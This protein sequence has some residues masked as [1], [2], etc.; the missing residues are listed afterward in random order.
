MALVLSDIESDTF[1]C[2][3]GRAE[4]SLLNTVNFEQSL[5]EQ[6]IDFCRLKVNSAD[7]NNYSALA[8]LNMPYQFCGSILKYKMD[9]FNLPKPSYK[10]KNLTFE[11]Y[12]PSTQQNILANLV[13]ET[14]INDPIGYYKNHL[15][16]KILTKQQEVKCMAQWYAKHCDENIN[17]MV[18]MKAGDQYIGY[19]SIFKKEPNLVDTPIAGVLPKFQGQKM[20]DDLRTYRHLY[21]LENNIQYG[22]AGARIE[23]NYSQQTFINDGMQQIANQSIYIVTPFLSKADSAKHTKANKLQADKTIFEQ[24][25]QQQGIHF[26]MEGDKQAYQKRSLYIKLSAIASYTLSVP[27]NLND[28]K[29]VL[30]KYFDKAGAL[31]L[32]NWFEH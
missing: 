13:N 2:K 31:C 10:N 26:F 30:V 27:V 32:I 15:L 21:C 22:T 23:N 24:L 18:L 16:S 20:F 17:I 12:K 7:L 5:I 6:S 14:F 11:V 28:K 1:D 3:V 25:H 8:K 19:I 29:L 4:T 9:F